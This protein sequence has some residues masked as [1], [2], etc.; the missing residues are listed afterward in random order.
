MNDKDLEG[1]VIFE[2]PE[3]ILNQDNFTFEA[4]EISKF[5]NHFDM[6]VPNRP[7]Y[8]VVIS[9]LSALQDFRSTSEPY[10]LFANLRN[11]SGT[12]EASLQVLNKM[13]DAIQSAIKQI[14]DQPISEE[15]KNILQMALT[16]AKK[17]INDRHAAWKKE[18]RFCSVWE[19]SDL[20]NNLDL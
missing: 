7:I 1:S 5:I 10:G 18:D 14:K 19:R 9:L 2:H 3:L 12:D 8:Q 17:S 6:A 11:D 20:K 13:H 4:G 16:Y 15:D